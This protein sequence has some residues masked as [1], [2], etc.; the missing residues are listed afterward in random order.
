MNERDFQLILRAKRQIDREKAMRSFFFVGICFVAV[1]RLVGLEVSFLYPLLF[2]VLF[3][4]LVL[5]SDFIANFGLVSK[6]DLVKLIEH[7]IHNDPD[8]LARYSELKSR[9]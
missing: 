5:N 3:V 9:I 2:I 4:S 1:L 6:R 8:T 7:H